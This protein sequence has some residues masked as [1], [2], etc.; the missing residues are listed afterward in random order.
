MKKEKEKEEKISKEEEI[1][2]K[3]DDNLDEKSDATEE[4]K[5]EEKEND[6]KENKKKK[7]K[8]KKIKN[9]EIEEETEEDKLIKETMGF[10]KFSS[11]KGKSHKDS[12]AS[13][14][15]LGRKAKRI[16]QRF[17]NY[18]PFSKILKQAYMSLNQEF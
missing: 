17:M 7:K 6:K 5:L 10:N 12:D 13:A 8:K 1:N 15:F 2:N 16:Y 9:I 18:K 11:T 3:E 14:V 4:L